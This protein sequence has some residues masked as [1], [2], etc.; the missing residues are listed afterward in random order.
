MVGVHVMV[1]GK[2][3]NTTSEVWHCKLADGMADIVSKTQTVW[4]SCAYV[5][6]V[7]S[8]LTFSFKSINKYKAT[9]TY[10][11]LIH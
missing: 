6:I 7:N 3:H 11:M 8:S 5:Y 10:I 2:L 4:N 1:E 9:K